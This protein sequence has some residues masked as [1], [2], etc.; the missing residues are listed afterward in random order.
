MFK[1]A[2]SQKAQAV[3]SH[4]SAFLMEWNFYLA[5]GSGLALQIGHRL[6]ED[7]DFFSPKFFNTQNLIQ[8][9]RSQTTDLHFILEEQSTLI[10]EYKDIHL[11]FFQYTV[12][13]IYPLAMIMEIPVADWRD[14]VAEK[15]KVLS[16]RGCKKDFYDLY[17]VFAFGHLT[18]QEGTSLFRKR[19]ENTGINLYHVLRSLTFFE[20]AEADPDPRLLLHHYSWEDVTRFFKE[21]IREFEKYLIEN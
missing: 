8:F 7:L 4:L 13:L 11:S 10:V 14:I 5:G 1:D 21:R 6:S 18:I 15:F 9:L 20:D 17:E 19:F 16:Q 12:P 2:L 3:L